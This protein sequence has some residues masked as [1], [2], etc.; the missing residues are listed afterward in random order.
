[1]KKLLPQDS[2]LR[3]LND[4]I[5]SPEN[6]ARDVLG[7]MVGFQRDCQVRL[8]LN[9]AA[10]A[11]DYA[12]EFLIYDDIDG[13]EV[14]F[15]QT[16]GVYLGRGHRAVTYDGTVLDRPWSQTAMKYTEVQQLIGE[17][18]AKRKET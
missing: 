18:S 2:T 3:T 12:V 10:K 16:A 4:V 11:P 13:E 17:L 7:N 8:A 6:F 15:P 1:M 5:R 14:A 9:S